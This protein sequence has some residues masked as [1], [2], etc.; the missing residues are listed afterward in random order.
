MY[1]YSTEVHGTLA[2]KNVTENNIHNQE[3]SNVGQATYILLCDI[4]RLKAKGFE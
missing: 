2:G 4:G 1:N 3:N